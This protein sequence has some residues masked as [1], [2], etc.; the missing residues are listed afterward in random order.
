MNKKKELLA[1]AI[2]ACSVLVLKGRMSAAHALVLIA[3]IE[4]SNQIKSNQIKSNE[5]RNSKS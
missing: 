5:N 4:K 3:A 2:G 1:S